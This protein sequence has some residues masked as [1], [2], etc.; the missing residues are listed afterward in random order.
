MNSVIYSEPFKTE[1]NFE[2]QFRFTLVDDKVEIDHIKCNEDDIDDMDIILIK[3]ILNDDLIN[4]KKLIDD[5]ID[6]RD[7]QIINFDNKSQ[8]EI[9]CLNSIK[10]LYE[11]LRENI[12]N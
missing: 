7:N 2:H 6:F 10:E 9:N 5:N 12:F 1:D 3:N 4:I 8:E 11:Y